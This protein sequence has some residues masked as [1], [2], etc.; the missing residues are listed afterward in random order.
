M[1]PNIVCLDGATLYDAASDEWNSLRKLGDLVI[2]DRTAVGEI[3]ERCADASIVLTN[4]VPFDARTIGALPALRYIGVLATGYNIIDT[5]AARAAG[6]TVTN[7]PAYS[8]DSVAQH[9]IALMLAAASGVERYTDSVKNGH[10]SS[11][12]DF[13]YRL[14]EWNELAGKTFGIVGLGSIGKAVAVIAEAFG[15]KIAVYTSKEQQELLAGYIKM[16]LDE[17]FASADVISLHCPLTE[18]TR[19]LVDTRRIALMKPTAIL[20]NTARGQLVDEH[21]LA[22]ALAEGRIFAAGCDVLSTEPPKADN[23]L[24]SAPRCYITP[25]IAWASVEARGRLMNIATDNV[26][27]FLA[28]NPMNVVG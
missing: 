14:R 26:R 16:E 2:Y 27:A 12:P 4:K 9:A 24:L 13:T 20:I 17:L 10:W 5:V 7:I 28:G 22:C 1:K 3:V 19:N 18:Q 23:P 15:M 21:A 25:H 8:T 6:V 11:Y